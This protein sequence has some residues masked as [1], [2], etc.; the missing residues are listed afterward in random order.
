MGKDVKGLVN[1]SF[2]KPIPILKALDIILQ[3]NNCKYEIKDNIIKVKAIVSLLKEKTFSLRYALATSLKD[4]VSSLLSPQGSLVISPENNLIQVKDTSEIIEKID[5]FIRDVD[6]PSS[7]MKTKSFSLKFALAKDVGD[8]LKGNLSSEGSLKINPSSNSILIKDT[9][10]NLSKLTP[11]ILSLD[12]FSPKQEIFQLRF[13]TSSDIVPL[14]KE[15]LSSKGSISL[16]EGNKIV[17]T[18][19]PLYVEKIGKSI[20]NLD[21]FSLWV[22]E[23]EFLIHYLSLKDILSEVKPLLSSEG[24]LKVNEEKNSII[25][26]D[27][28][29][30]IL[31]I[32]NLIKQKDIFIPEKRFYQLRFA[33]ASKLYLRIKKY[34]SDKGKCEVDKSNNTLDVVDV[35]KNL[36]IID[37]IVK[38]EDTLEKQLVM[39]VYTLRYF[40]PEEAKATLEGVI[41]EHGKVT[42]LSSGKERSNKEKDY[43]LIPQEK[44]DNQTNQANFGK[45]ELSSSYFNSKEATIVYVTDIQR[46]LSRIDKLVEQLNSP[47]WGSKLATR[48]FYIK[49]GSL[50]NIAKAIANIIGI[51]P[52]KIEGLQAKK[53]KWMEMQLSTPQIDVGNLGTIGKK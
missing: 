1:A 41:S 46:N 9:S 19:A 32:E 49:E 45:K 50:E 15:N 26:K 30:P 18:D 37:G 16:S 51:S 4:S 22:R 31:K 11:L 38:S 14:L 20:A 25:V 29:Y 21:K 36:S 17:V 42:I 34:L 13:A 43:I 24:Y 48:T 52:E 7:Q 47:T 40:T 12:K 39:R 35:E 27:A 33:S 2:S 5:A 6:N 23:K 8:V 28:S 3:R 44:E 53:S 10:Y